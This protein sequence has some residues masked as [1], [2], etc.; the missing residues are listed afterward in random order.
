MSGHYVAC[1]YKKNKWFILNDDEVSNY[2]ATD[3][4]LNSNNYM[5]FYKK[6]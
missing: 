1:V 3:V 5:L 4:K 6:K 2:E